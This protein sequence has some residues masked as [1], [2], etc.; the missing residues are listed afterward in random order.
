METKSTSFKNTTEL[1]K[2]LWDKKVRIILITFCGTLLVAL[3]SLLIPNKYKATAV[4]FGSEFYSMPKAVVSE[5]QLSEPFFDNY[6]LG[7][8]E[9][10]EQYIEIVKSEYV[11]DHLFEKFDLYGIYGVSPD[12]P[13]TRFL[14][15]YKLRK[16]IRI[17]KSR[18]TSVNIEVIDKN[19]K[20]AV[21]VA[22]TI[23]NYLDT[24]VYK[25]NQKKLNYEY[26]MVKKTMEIQQALV[27]SYQDSLS[28]V[29]DKK[30]SAEYIKFNQLLS[31]NIKKLSFYQ[32][33][34]NEAGFQLTNIPVYKFIV[35]YAK[36][37]EWKDS[38]KRTV[39]AIFSGF[40][41]FVLAVMVVLISDSL[42]R[43]LNS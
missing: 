19:P 43:I 37:P 25:M 31:D 39:I 26:A 14:I 15:E 36:L 7:D 30:N 16:Q 10:T 34:Y 5:Y 35:S 11:M 12:E 9:S 29:I 17:S 3:I 2:F 28:Q 18:Y 42:K 1:I 32:S 41:S 4:V 38:P 24:V 23:A 27:N 21:D 13:G 8:E 40:C 20:F 22:N 6:R 33:K